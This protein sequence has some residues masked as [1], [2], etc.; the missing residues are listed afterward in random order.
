M[1]ILEAKFLLAGGGADVIAKGAVAIGGGTIRDIGRTDEIVSRFSDAPRQQYANALLLPGFVNAH[2]HGRGLS[3]IQLGYTDDALEPWIARRRGRGAP[4]SYALTLL[5][6]EEMLANGVTSTLHANYSYASGDYEVELRGAIRAYEDAGLRATICIGYADRGGLVYPPAD[7]VSFR[8]SLSQEARQLLAAAKPAYLPLT[9]TL[10]LMSRLAD[11]YLGHPTITLAYGPAGPQ[12]VSDEAWRSLAKDA[13]RRGIGLHFHLLESPA[14]RRCAQV[15]YPEGVLTRLETLGLFETPASA[16]H[17]TQATPEDLA[18]AVRLGLVVVANP[19]SN[20]RLGNGVPAIADWRRAG[21]SVAVGTDNCALQDDEAYLSELR[22]AGV[23]ARIEDAKPRE[24]AARTLEMGT[25][26]GARAIFNPQIGRLEV[27]LRA[28]L[29]AIDLSRLSGS[30]LDADTDLLEAVMA[31]GKGEDVLMTMVEG[32]E[33]Y[34]RGND[35][36]RR[37]AAV[38]AAASA[39]AARCSGESARLAGEEIAQAL[40]HHYR[41]GDA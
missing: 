11:E 19:G 12:W 5:A 6:A 35:R 7:V 10:N 28:D 22:L 18:D 38:T 39:K 40:R 16:A 41:K 9:Q 32:V 2:Q 20:M 17:F 29:V 8:N 1:R 23:L 15:L 26:M 25:F 30:Y 27:G 31:R 37:E 3:Q 21:L 13:A 4:D 34:R 14:Q 24:S 36:R 33:R